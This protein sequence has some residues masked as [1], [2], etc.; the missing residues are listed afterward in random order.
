MIR[1]AHLTR[2]FGSVVAVDDVSFEIERGR[3]VGFLGPNGAGKTTTMQMLVGVLAPTSGQCVIGGVDVAQSPVKAHQQIGWLPEGAPA[4]DELRV[5]EYLRFR[6]GLYDPSTALAVPEVIERC[7]LTE[8]RRRIVGQLSRGFRQRVGLAAAIINDPSV[9]ILD[10]PGTGLD[11]VQQRA[12]RGLVRDLAEDRAI[13]FSTHQLGEAIDVCDDL[14]IIGG[15]KLL[16]DSSLAEVK[17]S[18]MS[19]AT[20]LVET[21]GI[22][23]ASV[24]GRIDSCRVL[25]VRPIDSEWSQSR[26]LVPQEAHAAIAAAVTSAGGG[27]RALQVETATLESWV[28]SVLQG[29]AA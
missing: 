19:S 8:V 15:G 7:Q 9:L 10:E 25:E 5:D 2:R 20:L 6:R 14:L 23:A 3:V 29:D 21:R 17:Q 11:P 27:L 28:H 26:C 13:L 24:L 18:A 4:C 16:A 12:F 22:D 1:A